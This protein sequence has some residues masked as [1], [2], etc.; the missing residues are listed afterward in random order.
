MRRTATENK[1]VQ[2]C[3]KSRKG[4]GRSEESLDYSTVKR[5]SD[6][7]QSLRIKQGEG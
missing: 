7:E 2:A 1:R 6:S 3:P 4:Q 5:S